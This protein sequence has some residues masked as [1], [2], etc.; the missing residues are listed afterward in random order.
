MLLYGPFEVREAAVGSDHLEWLMV[1]F[2]Q[3]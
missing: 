3:D 2:V 1:A